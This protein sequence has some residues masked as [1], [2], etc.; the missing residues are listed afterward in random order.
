MNLEV[1]YSLN[2]VK[3]AGVRNLE[4]EVLPLKDIIKDILETG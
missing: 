3:S 4:T 2:V 1:F